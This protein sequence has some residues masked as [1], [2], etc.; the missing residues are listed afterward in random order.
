LNPESN[1]IIEYQ[2][3]QILHHRLAAH[4]LDDDCISQVVDRRFVCGDTDLQGVIFW[5]ARFLLL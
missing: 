5:G 3:E 2:L 1:N 4:P